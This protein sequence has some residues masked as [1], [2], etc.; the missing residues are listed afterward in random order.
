MAAVAASASAAAFSAASSA[1]RCAHSCVTSL[2]MPTKCVTRPS[3]ARM[4]VSDS[5]FWN[6]VPSL[7]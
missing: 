7:R 6:G 4:G 3:G 2:W 1:S 5:A